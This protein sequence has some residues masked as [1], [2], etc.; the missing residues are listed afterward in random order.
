MAKQHFYS[1]VPFRASMFNRADGYDTFA[2]SEGLEREFIDKE[3]GVVCESKPTA[4]ESVLIR[5]GELSPVYCAYTAKDGTL[6]QSCTTFM[7]LDYTGERSTYLVHNL[8]FDPQETA[9]LFYSPTRALFNEAM[10]DHDIGHFDITSLTAQP[11]PKYPEL[12]FKYVTA[13][14]PKWLTEELDEAMVQ[15][16]LYC[17]V[18]VICGNIKGLYVLLPDKG[19]DYILK[20]YNT[21]YSIIPYHLRPLLSFASRVPDTSRYA[22]FKVKI[23]ADLFNILPS[24]GAMLNF[25]S[26]QY[27]GMKDDDIKQVSQI[28]EFFYTMLKN[29]TIRDEFLI[30]TDHA[31][32]E[33]PALGQP[34]IK[35]LNNLVFIFR[36]GSGF[37]DEK[38][39]LG[40][41][42]K[43]L[44]YFTV[45]EKYRA[46]LSNDF[47]TTAAKSLKRYPENHKAIPPKVFAKIAKIYPTDM[48]AV[49]YIIMQVVLE[50]IHMDIMRD[51]LFQFVKAN[52]D[53]Q[54]REE[55]DE[56]IK[57]IGRVFYGGFLQSQILAFFEQIFDSES[58][59][60]Q[61]EIMDRLLLSIRNNDIKDQILGFLEGHFSGFTPEIRH[62]VYV[63]AVEHI[64]EGDA[65][66]SKLV[67]LIDNNMPGEPDE[68]KNWFELKL[69]SAATAEQRK[70]NHPMLKLLASKQGFCS[71]L[72]LK[73]VFNEELGKKAYND[74]LSSFCAGGLKNLA[75]SLKQA[76]PLLPD[77][78]EES[79]ERLFISIETYM[80]SEQKK[81]DLPSVLAADKIIAECYEEEEEP[82]AVM[83][84]QDFSE[85]VIAPALRDAI[86]DVFRYQTQPQ[87]LDEAFIVT[88]KYDA[89]KTTD[90]YKFMLFYKNVELGIDNADF[91]KILGS[92]NMM[93]QDLIRRKQ[94]GEFMKK[95]LDAKIKE[96]SPLVNA[97]MVALI[98]YLRT[99]CY[100][101]V[102]LY[103]KAKECLEG[104]EQTSEPQ[105]PVKGKKKEPAADHPFEAIKMVLF[106]GNTVNSMCGQQMKDALYADNSYLLA[107]FNSYIGVNKNQEKKK[108][109]AAIDELKPL[110]NEFSVKCEN[111][112]KNSGQKSSFFGN[113][114]KKK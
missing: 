6:V 66:A 102:G 9:S 110:K 109:S 112:I 93:P 74:V 55:K 68:E 2:C 72:V 37:F 26:N 39:V 97:S 10:F 80:E 71:Q 90:A 85:Q 104:A 24:K 114:F 1:R 89:V 67:D 108:L 107:S 60:S 57:N 100:D 58:P 11:L 18:S 53:S 103:D 41:D 21:I 36:C 34:S 81:F 91:E 73:K 43:L 106:F 20:F 7:P 92:I 95:N 22:N 63:A 84:W 40:T 111:L 48:P 51:K 47:R 78:D 61:L 27:T 105:P 12:D 52:Y 35:M 17:V 94:V 16:L 45:Y 19:N 69:V 86:P 64:Q 54:T 98:S 49:K 88:D 38:A 99:G 4:E 44:E 113:L 70:R 75:L 82:F 28:V 83:F 42:D 5:K 50:L 30:F 46:A 25:K 14:N 96:S 76:M 8:L 101:F 13:E 56:I 23:M 33:L 32:K 65:L 59:E 15:R 29:E 87:I 3:L 77:I 31:V 79:N 62:N